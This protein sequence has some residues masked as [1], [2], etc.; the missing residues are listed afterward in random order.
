MLPLIV[1]PG[2]EIGTVPVLIRTRTSIRPDNIRFIGVHKL[3]EFWH[4]FTLRIFN[5]LGYI[6]E[7]ISQNESSCGP[8]LLYK[9]LNIERYLKDKGR[10]ITASIKQ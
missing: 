2:Y 6:C 4:R 8:K 3:I 10:N 9:M 1:Q 7:E 5:G